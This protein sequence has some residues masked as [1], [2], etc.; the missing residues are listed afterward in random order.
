MSILENRI[1]GEYV[2]DIEFWG[3]PLVHL[4]LTLTKGNLQEIIYTSIYGRNL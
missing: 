1:I 2:S 4:N 3:E